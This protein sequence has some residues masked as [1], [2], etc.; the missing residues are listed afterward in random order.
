MSTCGFE[1][2]LWH[3]TNGTVPCARVSAEENVGCALRL[4]CCRLAPAERITVFAPEGFP[5]FRCARCGLC[6]V[7]P[8]Q[9]TVS[10]AKREKLARLLAESRFPIPVRDALVQPEDDPEAAASFARVGENCVFLTAE[11]RCRL[12][13]LGASGLRGGWCISFPV[14]PILTPRGANYSLSFA[15]PEVARILRARQPL[16][17][18]ALT[19]AGTQLPAAGA[20]FPAHHL[21]PTVRGRPKLDWAAYRLVEGMLLAVARSWEIRLADRLTVMPILLGYLLGDYTGP[22]GDAALRERISE[23]GHRLGEMVKQARSFRPDHAAHHAALSALLG[24]RVGLRSRTPSRKL[25][26]SAAQELRRRQSGPHG[27]AAAMAELYR[28][29]YKPA[30]ASVE[31]ILGNY[32]ICRLF[33]SQEALVGGV[34]KGVYATIYLVA[35][36]RF[37]AAVG[38]AEVGGRVTVGGL[39]DAVHAVEKFFTPSR[40]LLEFLDADME[41]ERMLDSRYAAALV[42]I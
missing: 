18:L 26:D 19:V 37:F 34:Y 23:A 31:H 10:A 16:N 21:I 8:P 27:P 15:C 41:Q 3:Q 6:C 24:R 4:G 9:I 20:S 32:V 22:G 36:I 14:S 38:A 1:S 40:T 25:V 7:E 35:L 12:C 28:T 30:A 13:E 42:R 17:L 5:G 39:L 33:A 29:H 2:H 11:G